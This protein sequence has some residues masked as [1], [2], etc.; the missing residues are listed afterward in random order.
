[1]QPV[2]ADILY[3]EDGLALIR[4]AAIAISG[5]LVAATLMR[6]RNK[7]LSCE[8]EHVHCFHLTDLVEPSFNINWLNVA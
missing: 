6:K 5:L 7:I 8:N 4:V 3:V 1:M 2:E